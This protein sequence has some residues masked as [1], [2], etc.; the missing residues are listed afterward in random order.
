MDLAAEYLVAMDLRVGLFNGY[1]V[2]FERWRYCF[3]GSVLDGKLG[4]STFA[5]TE[6]EPFSIL[7]LCLRVVDDLLE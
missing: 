6:N 5:G 3:A 1:I 4:H 7:W 2:L